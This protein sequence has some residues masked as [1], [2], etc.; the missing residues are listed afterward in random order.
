MSCCEVTGAKTCRTSQA[1]ISVRR[2]YPQ[3]L[4][5]MDSHDSWRNAPRVHLLNG[6][7]G[8]KTQR[9]YLAGLTISIARIYTYGQGTEGEVEDVGFKAQKRGCERS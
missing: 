2:R 6:R 3:Q 9:T 7:E 8:R 1:H 4:A 5:C